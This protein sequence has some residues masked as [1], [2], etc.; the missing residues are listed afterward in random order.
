MSTF[1]E[2]L[3]KEI[4]LYMV[5]LSYYN[6]RLIDEDAE[7]LKKAIVKAKEKF[8][9]KYSQYREQNNH[10]NHVIECLNSFDDTIKRIH[11]LAECKQNSQEIQVQY[12]KLLEIKSIVRKCFPNWRNKHGGVNSTINELKRMIQDNNSTIACG[13]WREL[14]Q[15]LDGIDKKDAEEY[16][17]DLSNIVMDEVILNANNYPNLIQVVKLLTF[18]R[19]VINLFPNLPDTFSIV[20]REKY[21]EICDKYKGNDYEIGKKQTNKAVFKSITLPCKIERD[22][23]N[24][25]SFFAFMDNVKMTSTCYPILRDAFLADI[26]QILDNLPDIDL[27]GVVNELMIKYVFSTPR[28]ISLDYI[29]DFAMLTKLY[30]ETPEQILITEQRY[31]RTKEI[32]MQ[33]EQAE[34]DRKERARQAREERRMYKE[35]QEENRRHERELQRELQQEQFRRD[36]RLERERQEATDRRIREERAYQERQ[37]NARRRNE[38]QEALRKQSEEF[39]AKND[40]RHLCWRCANYGHG[41]QGGVLGCGNFRSK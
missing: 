39:K 24:K 32:E 4:D 34:L 20:C 5:N 6:G 14:T 15:Y 40:M 29:Y 38:Q 28:E 31:F 7:I 25:P 2:A 10:Y 22:I 17:N 35:E 41:C 16:L 8:T 27:L 21:T 23:R 13:D 19:G 3:K 11:E 9:A 30:R 12:A 33:R 18:Y 36:A 1:S 37:E 26:L